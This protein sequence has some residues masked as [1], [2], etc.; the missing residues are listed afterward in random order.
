MTDTAQLNL[1]EPAQVDWDNY[2]AGGSTYTP[3]PPVLD[4]SGKPITYFGVA[5]I[6]ADGG[7]REGYLTFLLDP[8]KIVKSGSADGYTLRFTRASVAP[9]TKKDPNTGERVPIKGNPNAVGNFLRACG[10]TVKPQ[11]NSE[12]TAA[13]S[14]AAGKVFPFTIEWEAYNKDT[15]E[16]VK[17]YKAFPEDP[18]RPGQRKS[19]LKQGD[20][21][22]VLD[23]KGNVLEVKQVESEVLFAN[24]RLRF[25]QDPSR[26]RG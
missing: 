10:L 19:I 9:F 13:M 8:I 25:F 15:G 3:P 6:K 4:A 23:N 22:N 2:N 5:E 20:F 21:Y 1:R 16:R 24:A 12:Y 11:T 14:R 7:D 18:E 17:G 26:T